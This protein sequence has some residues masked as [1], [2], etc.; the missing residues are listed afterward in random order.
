[1]LAPWGED[2]NTK[3]K[4]PRGTGLVVRLPGRGAGP[5]GR[6]ARKRRGRQAEL[7]RFV[8]WVFF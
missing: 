8:D 3:K 2:D 4:D 7:G 6:K 5:K 1:V